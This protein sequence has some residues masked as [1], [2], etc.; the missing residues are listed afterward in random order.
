[1]ECREEEV[2]PAAEAAWVFLGILSS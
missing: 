1:M 2:L